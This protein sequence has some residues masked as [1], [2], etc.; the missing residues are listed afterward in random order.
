MDPIG[1]LF[2]LPSSSLQATQLTRFRHWI[3]MDLDRSLVPWFLATPAAMNAAVS[4]RAS[5]MFHNSY[6]LYEDR[7]TFELVKERK[8]ENEL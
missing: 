1:N 3:P 8:R 7:Y 5:T 2:S 4:E 6:S